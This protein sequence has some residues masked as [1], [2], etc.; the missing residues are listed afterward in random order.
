MLDPNLPFRLLDLEVERAFPQ[1]HELIVVVVESD[2]AERAEEVADENGR[3]A[4]RDTDVIPIH[5]SA[6]ERAILCTKTVCSTSI[7]MIYGRSMNV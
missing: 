3:P 6:W 2:T 7:S 1:L 4:S 5:L